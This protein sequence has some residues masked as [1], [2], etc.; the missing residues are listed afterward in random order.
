MTKTAGP[1]IHAIAET[2]RHAHPDDAGPDAG[3]DGAPGVAPDA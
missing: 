1:T 3:P 2:K